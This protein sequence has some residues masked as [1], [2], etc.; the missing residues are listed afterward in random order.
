MVRAFRQELVG[1]PPA[2]PEAA[3]AALG[4]GMAEEGPPGLDDP[5]DDADFIGEEV[6]VSHARLSVRVT[7]PAG[8]FRRWR[9]LLPR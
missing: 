8:E 5:H 6:P 7:T 3:P 2:V 9:Q 1:I 4:A